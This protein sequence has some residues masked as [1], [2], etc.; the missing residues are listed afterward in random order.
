M[1]SASVNHWILWVFRLRCG[2]E[3]PNNG[4]TSSRCA[5]GAAVVRALALEILYVYIY[6]RIEIHSQKY[7]AC[8]SKCK[9]MNGKPRPSQKVVYVPIYRIATRLA[10]FYLPTTQ[11]LKKAF[12]LC[13]I[14]NTGD[15]GLGWPCVNYEPR[16]FVS[17]H[18]LLEN[19]LVMLP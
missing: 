11:I 18:Q 17:E 14:P 7:K 10:L 19:I 5:G 8:W 15:W 4:H 2:R 3:E 16:W 6:T 9:H 12:S 1:S 13:K